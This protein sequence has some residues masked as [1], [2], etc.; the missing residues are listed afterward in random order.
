MSAQEMA[1]MVADIL[2]PLVNE[3]SQRSEERLRTVINDANNE[4]RRLELQITE[5]RE[6]QEQGEA[7]RGA[8][9]DVTRTIMD[10]KGYQKIEKFKDGST[11]WKT[12][13]MQFENLT[14]LVYPGVGRQ[15]LRWARSIGADELRFNE[16]TRLFNFHPPNEVTH[17]QAHAIGQDLAMALS[18]VLDG[19]AEAIMCNAGE[20]AGLDA[21]RRLQQRFDPRSNARDLVDSQRVIHPPQCKTLQ[22]MLPAL[23][24]WEE[25]IR[26]MNPDN[27]PPMLIQMGIA[28]S[29]CP[30][31]LQEHLQDMEDRI[32][33]YQQLRSE[34]I[35]K[36]DLA[37]VTKRSTTASRSDYMDIGGLSN[38][39]Y[40]REDESWTWPQY[41]QDNC[42]PWWSGEIDLAALQPWKGGKGKGKKGDPKGKGKGMWSPMYPYQKGGKSDVKGDGKKVASRS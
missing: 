13:R 4:I 17:Q 11:R 40:E 19:E 1:T 6:H 18:Y 9:R 38:H 5:L 24:R 22:E 25:A 3:L 12:I 27:R 28:I 30:P 15:L 36:V 31:K 8:R 16:Q 37:E 41:D 35:R 23:E 32:Q 42:S 29:M 21:W 7:A 14:E 26:Q 33:N 39:D 10:H 2:R 34:I 20:G